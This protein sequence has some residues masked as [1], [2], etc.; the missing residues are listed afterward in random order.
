MAY[1]P[2]ECSLPCRPL[3]AR[4][5][6]WREMTVFDYATLEILLAASRQRCRSLPA[7][8]ARLRRIRGR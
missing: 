5:D 3:E 1:I 4:P 2:G 7:C 8:A 6:D